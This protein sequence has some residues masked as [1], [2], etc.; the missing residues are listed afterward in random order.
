MV[1]HEQMAASFACRI[2]VSYGIFIMAGRIA[3]L[4]AV[5]AVNVQATRAAIANPVK[6]LR[7]G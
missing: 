7:T 1:C 2:P 6:S 4:I 5:I 3:V